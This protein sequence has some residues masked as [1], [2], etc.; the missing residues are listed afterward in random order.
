[1]PGGAITMQDQVVGEWYRSESRYGP[2]FHAHLRPAQENSGRLVTL[3]KQQA[4]LLALDEAYDLVLVDG[5]PGIGCPVISALPARI[6]PSLWPNR[7]RRASMIW[8]G[9][10]RPPRIWRGS[11]GVHQQGRHLPGRC[12]PD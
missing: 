8:R 2:L 12:G 5:P 1:M 10:W 7:R 3:V 4:R 9:C 6:W 11:A